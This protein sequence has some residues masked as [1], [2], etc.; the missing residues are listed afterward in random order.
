MLVVSELYSDDKGRFLLFM[1]SGVIENDKGI[2]GKMN[3]SAG[4]AQGILAVEV[5]QLCASPPSPAEPGRCW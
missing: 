3:R 2:W 4:S 5:T 1:H